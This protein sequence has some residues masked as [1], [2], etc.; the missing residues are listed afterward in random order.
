MKRAAVLAL[1][2]GCSFHTSIETGHDAT[3]GEAAVDTP[4][5]LSSGHDTDG[6]GIDDSVD[7][8]PTVANPDQHDED[9]DHVGDACDPCPQVA[10]ATT[11]SDGDGIPDACD[12]HPNAPGD[13]LDQFFAFTGTTLPAGWTALSGNA[14]DWTVASDA[15]TINTS[16]NNTHILSF[17]DSH[18]HHAID[19]GFDVAANN[20]GL[21]A[22]AFATALID[23]TTDLSEF[24]GCGL[25]LDAPSFRE[26]FVFDAQDNPQFIP[27]ATVTADAPTVP[28]SYRVVAVQDPDGESCDIPGAMG[29]HPMAGGEPSR[30]NQ[31]VGLRAK[32]VTIH[33]RY[34]AV[35]HF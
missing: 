25:R 13:V 22:Q 27:Q 6:D 9:G 14:G 23:L 11:D 8:C 17:L 29:S 30:Q 12:P 5:D 35:Y 10:N 34:V 1:A 16:D 20:A 31:H 18:S 32:N 7:N 15:L 2:A 4:P 3:P 26:L 28:G 19:V 33:V 21:G 24:N